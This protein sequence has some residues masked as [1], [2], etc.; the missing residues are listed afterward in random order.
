M[1]ARPNLYPAEV[2]VCRDVAAD[3]G[4]RTTCVQCEAGS[5]PRNIMG[6]IV[7]DLQVGCQI[8]LT[9]LPQAQP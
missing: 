8:S 5:T 6:A 7:A 4:L 3:A 1:R 2:P 9:V